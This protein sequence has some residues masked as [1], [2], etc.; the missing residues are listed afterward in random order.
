MR[1]RANTKFCGLNL[2]YDAETIHDESRLKDTVKFDD[3]KKSLFFPAEQDL[4]PVL[5]GVVGKVIT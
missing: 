1:Q 4:M 5:L 2:T 3:K